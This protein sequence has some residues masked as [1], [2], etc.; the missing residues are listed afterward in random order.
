MLAPLFIVFV[1]LVFL[2]VCAV[3]DFLGIMKE[4]RDW[5]DQ[6][7]EEW[8]KWEA[9]RQQREELSSPGEAKAAGG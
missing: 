1:A 2:A 4:P 7:R 9:E 8:V 3:L 6:A 5:S